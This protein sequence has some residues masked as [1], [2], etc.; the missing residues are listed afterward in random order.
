MPRLLLGESLKPSSSGDRAAAEGARTENHLGP[1]RPGRG[2]ILYSTLHRPRR[3]SPWEVY[4]SFPISTGRDKS[5]SYFLLERLVGLTR[6][7]QITEIAALAVWI[8]ASG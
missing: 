8:E 1:S 4:R 2:F 3:D 5:N 6:T 7:A